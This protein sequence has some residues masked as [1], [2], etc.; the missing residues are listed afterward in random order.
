MK[1][2]IFFNEGG[3]ASAPFELMVAVIIMSFV[4]VVG[5]MVLDTVNTQVCLNSV[6][7]EMTE[8]KLALEDSVARMSST[9]LVFRPEGT[10]FSSKKSTLKIY[11]EETRSVCSSVCGFAANSCFI[12]VFSSKMPGISTK[13][14]CLNLP[15]FT[16]FQEEPTCTDMV[17]QGQGFSTI[18]PTIEGEFLPG[19]YVIRNIS[20]V[21]DHF[22]RICVW[23]KAV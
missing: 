18:D 11:N 2:N 4:M 6:D 13:R 5:Y 17:L 20:S 19:S 1:K 22:P 21:G 7:R 15:A 10:C 12:M 23:Y 3:Q 14:K 8:F 9:P 16:S